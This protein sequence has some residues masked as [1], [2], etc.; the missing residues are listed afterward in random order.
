[1]RRTC[2][3]LDTMRNNVVG[4]LVL[5][6]LGT[7]C[8]SLEM[9]GTPFYTGEYTKRQGPVEDRVNLWPVMYYREPALSVLWPLLEFTDTHMAFRPLFSVYGLEQ[10]N[11]VYNVLW[12]LMQFDQQSK[13]HYIFPFFWGDSYGVGFPLFWHSVHPLDER[14]G[15]YD[16]LFPLWGINRDSVHYSWYA[17]WPFIHGERDGHGSGGH[18]LPLFGR[19]D[20]AGGYIQFEGLLAYQWS[21]RNAHEVGHALLPLYWYSRDED[22]SCFFSLPWWYQSK[23][24]GEDWQCLPP[25]FFRYADPTGSKIFTPVWLKNSSADGLEGWHAVLPLYYS[26]KDGTLLSLPFMRWRDGNQATTVIPPLLSWSTS[27]PQGHDTWLA[28]P[29]VHSRCDTASSVQHVLPFFYSASDSN[30]ATFISLPWSSSADSNGEAWRLLPPLFYQ[31][32]GTNHSTII[33]PLWASGHDQSA[34]WQ[35]LIPLYFSRTNETGQVLA[36]LLGGYRTDETSAHWLAYPLLSWGGRTQEGG[37]VW[38]LAPLVHGRWGK[39]GGA[40][41][42]LPFYYWDGQDKTF[43]SLPWCRW[44]EE[45]EHTTVIPPA[46]SWLHSTPEYEDL[47]LAGGLAH[48]SWG[49]QPNSQYVL[50]LFYNNPSTGTQLTPLWSRWGDATNQTTML[51]FALSW[52]TQQPGCDDLWLLGPL[53]HWSWGAQAGSQ[54]LLPLFYNNSITGTQLTPLW[55]HWKDGEQQKTVIPLALSQ[56]TKKDDERELSVALGLFHNQRDAQGQHRSQLVPVYTYN[57]DDQSFLTP[58][59]GWQRGERGWVYPVTPLL[60]LLTG[61]EHS[62]G[63]VFPL[64]SHVRDTTSGDISDWFLW[65]HYWKRQMQ[66]RS[67]FF[68]F[69]GYTN[70]GA[71]GSESPPEQRY[72][73]TYGKDFFCIPYSWYRNTE[74]VHPVVLKTRQHEVMPAPLVRDRHLEHGVFPLWSHTAFVSGDQT[75]TNVDT[76]VLLML[77]DYKRDVQAATATQ[78]EATDYIRSRVLWRLWHYEQTNCTVSVDLFPGITYDRKPDGFKKISWLWRLFRYERDPDGGHK[79][80]LLFIPFVRSGGET[81][82]H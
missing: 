63:W 68:P 81:T 50:P 7:G 56:Y 12:P 44:G 53:A 82:V 49:A 80:D 67:I 1:M 30:R 46:L 16:W 70:F 60:G 51:P 69:Y 77:Y 9:K 6:L 2:Q 35:T 45:K 11:H 78:L 66:S 57:R 71:L 8:S 73:A 54:H 13:D 33:T 65:G 72:G 31:S 64:Y 10:S 52:L 14:V 29:L 28:G 38:A 55:W 58:L 32:S 79:F 25:V 17:L 4:L 19:Y 39:D 40:S 5:L 47:W 62:G 26:N 76:S 61:Q 42:V 48:W 18:F 3:A 41:H 27:S 15:G 37:E 43:L 23:V 22:G 59:F 21:S 34:A 20:D 36:T 24:S 74:T 75:R